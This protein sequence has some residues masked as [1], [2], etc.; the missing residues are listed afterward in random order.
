MRATMPARRLTAAIVLSLLVVAGLVACRSDP[1]VAAY[2]GDTEIPVE[3]VNAV[4]DA[5]RATEE[6]QIEEDLAR[7]VAQ[8]EEQEVEV[9]EEALAQNRRLRLDNLESNLVAA[10][11]EVATFLVL[12]VAGTRYAEREG[13]A[14]PEPRP[15]E[16]AQHFDVEDGEHPYAQ[17]R[18]E[19]EAVLA[20]LAEQVTLTDPSEADQREAYQNIQ[21]PPDQELL[22]FDEV[23]EHFNVETIG[24]PVG[25][26][27]LLVEV[28]E[29]EEVRVQPGFDLLY[30]VPVQIG[31]AASFLVVRVSEPSSVQDAS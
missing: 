26:R 30:R 15:D 7:M 17:V 10:R 21:V 14:L 25:L 5:L 19:F 13:I 18:A 31:M 4:L 12:T 3:R 27:D 22:P 16:I 1:A 23:Q 28:I 9:S 24:F 20:A 11:D 2:V 6:A 8:A 29:Q